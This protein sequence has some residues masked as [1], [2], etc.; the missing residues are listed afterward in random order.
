MIVISPQHGHLK[1]RVAELDNSVQLQ[2]VN[3]SFGQVLN[4][5]LT[6]QTIL[7]DNAGYVVW[8]RDGAIDSE[9]A[10]AGMVALA[11]LPEFQRSVPQ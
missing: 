11:H 5:F 7:L 6:P 2:F 10:H 4:P 8:S 1:A 3:M 9:A